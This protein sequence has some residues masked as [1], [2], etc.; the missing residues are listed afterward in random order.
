MPAIRFFLPL[1]RRDSSILYFLVHAVPQNW[2][3]TPC[4]MQTDLTL[5]TLWAEVQRSKATLCEKM[6][7]CRDLQA[8]SSPSLHI[9]L[10][11]T[12]LKLK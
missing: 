7:Y 5:Y 10:N 1:L 11:L 4:Y 3:E 2:N 12:I 9:V 8:A 6:R